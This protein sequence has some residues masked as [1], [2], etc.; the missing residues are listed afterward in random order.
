M[1]DRYERKE[2][3]RGRTKGHHKFKVCSGKKSTVAEPAAADSLRMDL[4]CQVQE[5]R[6]LV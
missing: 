6:V 1:N 3:K 4:G 5:G 2:R